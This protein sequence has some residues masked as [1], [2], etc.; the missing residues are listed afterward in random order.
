MEKSKV[1]RMKTV[2]Q[3]KRLSND[4]IAEV[5]SLFKQSDSVEFKLIVPDTDRMAAVNALAMDALDAEIRQVVF[6]DTPDLK[7]SRAGII[8]RARRIRKGG[9]TVVKLR[10]LNPDRLAEKLRRSGSFVTEVDLTP[11]SFV[12]SGS[13]K[14]KVDNHSVIETLAGARRIRKLFSPEQRAFYQ[15]HAP[16]NLDMNSLM[17][18]GPINV[19]KLKFSPEALS[20]RSMTAE[21]WFY[22]DNERMLEL[23][24]KCAPSDAYQILVELR[25]Y[26]AKCG[27]EVDGAQQTK[28]QKALEYFSRLY[29]RNGNGKRSSLRKAG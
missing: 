28:T 15:D 14:G 29:A 16:K 11:G 12:C 1:A 2:A 13:M 8:V 18:F 3:P 4:E 23:S 17:P 9:D 21:L 24:V 20:N 27:I 5:V 25:A 22:P 6:F 19:A 10:P 7:L 26:L